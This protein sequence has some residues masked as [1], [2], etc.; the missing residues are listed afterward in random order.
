MKYK[1][2]SVIT[3]FPLSNNIQSIQLC[4]RVL[5]TLVTG[6]STLM[7]LMFSVEAALGSKY[8]KL[9]YNNK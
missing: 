1:Q 2:G 4:F 3:F 6:L 9:K 8:L 5:Y 7:V